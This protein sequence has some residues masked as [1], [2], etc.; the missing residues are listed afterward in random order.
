MAGAVGCEVDFVGGRV[1]ALALEVVLEPADGADAVIEPGGGF[2]VAVAFSR[3]FDEADG[4][5]AM[6]FE[7]TEQFA[8]LGGVDAGIGFAVEDE[9]W[10]A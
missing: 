4:G 10:G 9:Q 6:G 1:S 7:V 2:T 5:I 8:G 3:I